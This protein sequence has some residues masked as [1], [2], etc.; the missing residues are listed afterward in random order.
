MKKISL[1]VILLYIVSA[2]FACPIC[3]CGVG[4]F[5]IGL[6]PTYTGK[7]LGVRYQYSHYETRLR[8]DPEQYSHDYYKLAELYGGITIGTKWQILG[9]IPYHFNYQNTDDGIKRKNGLGDATFIANYKVWQATSLDKTN[10]QV[11]QQLWLG[12][13][14]KLPTGQHNVDF[15]NSQSQ[16]LEELLGDV[17]SEMGTGSLDF[18]ANAMYNLNFNRWGINTTVNY[19]I[20]TKNK[21]DFLYGDRLTANSFAYYQAML[22]KSVF[23]APNVG[24]LYEH[25]SANYLNKNKVDETGGYAALASA[26]V[27]VNIKKMT[28]GAN[29]QLP[30]AQDYALGQTQY[31][32]RG[33]VHLTYTF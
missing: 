2:S 21:S 1:S 6:L 9:F 31:K 27:D 28:V 5:Y 29:I 32:T 4:G 13:G 8:S 26:G 7:F 12:G 25:I 33:L 17:N 23:V 22:K 20:N 14:L 15:K 3:G 16:D 11:S 30:F 10:K 19:K 24:L 18:I